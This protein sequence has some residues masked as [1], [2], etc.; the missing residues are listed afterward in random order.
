MVITNQTRWLTFFRCHEVVKE[1]RTF[2]RYNLTDI[3]SLPAGQVV[4]HPRT[5]WNVIKTYLVTYISVFE[6]TNCI[7]FIEMNCGRVV[8]GSDRLF[9][10]DSK[11]KDFS[12]SYNFSQEAQLGETNCGSSNGN[13]L[14]MFVLDI[15][16]LFFFAMLASRQS[17]NLISLPH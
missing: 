1:L 4:P 8:K 12:W 17:E 16:G 10:N 13:L 7:W 5:H 14:I 15:I 6:K 9:F 3:G 2:D 11:F